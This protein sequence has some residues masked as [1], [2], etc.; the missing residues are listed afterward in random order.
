MIIFLFLIFLKRHFVEFVKFPKLFFLFRF[1]NGW[2]SHGVNLR[3][4]TS[5]SRWWR[6]K[7]WRNAHQRCSIS[8]WMRTNWRTRANTSPITSK[9]IGERPIHRLRRHRNP[10]FQDRRWRPALRSHHL[11]IIPT[12]IHDWLPDGTWPLHQVHRCYLIYGNIWSSF[13]FFSPLTLS[14][15]LAQNIQIFSLATFDYFVEKYWLGIS[16]SRLLSL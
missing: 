12:I 2:S 8:S 9:P 16:A 13:F 11:S 10:P 6:P 15:R 5:T 4:A 3:A 1:C 14:D 7:S